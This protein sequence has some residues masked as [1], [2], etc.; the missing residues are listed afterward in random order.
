MITM[1]HENITKERISAVGYCRYS[2]DMQRDESIEAQKRAIFLFADQFGYEIKEFYVDKAKSG[3]YNNRPEFLRLHENSAKGIFKTVIIHKLDRYS[4][5]VG[6]THQYG[7]ILKSNGVSL[8]SVSEKLD[9]SPIGELMLTFMAGINRY[10]VANL[11]LEVKKGHK[12]NVYQGKTTGGNAPLGLDIVDKKYVINP[13]EAPIIRLVFQMYDEGFGYNEIIKKLKH[14]GYKSR[15]N[16]PFGKNSLYSI[17]HNEKY[18][19]HM[20]YGKSFVSNAFGKR[21]MR[22]SLE[23]ENII[24]A[25]DVIPPIIS[26]DRWERV[27]Q[28]LNFNK[29]R[30]GSYLAKNNYLL[31]GLV[32]CGECGFA[33]HGNSRRPAKDRPYY[34]SYRCNH[35]D[36]NLNC[37]CKEIKRD[38]LEEFV[39]EQLKQ[40][41]L[42]DSIIPR[43]TKEV[44]SYIQQENENKG[45]NDHQIE[46]NLKRLQ[47]EKDNMVEAIAQVG[48]NDSFAKKLKSIEEQIGV[49]EQKKNIEKRPT[50]SNITVTQ[51]MLKEFLD[52]QLDTEDKA[53]LKNVLQHYIE[54]IEVSNEQ[55]Q[56]IFKIAVASEQ[57]LVNLNIVRKIER[58]HLTA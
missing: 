39:V 3:K 1:N 2:S 48:F 33:M 51:N 57:D 44:N 24:T 46:L 25:Q 49:I 17:L 11:S 31:S 8:V 52:K 13:Q 36:N 38:L 16:R 40:Y 35:K 41:M 6:D 7:K 23:D 27:Q 50:I 26:K 22:K 9:D 18:V 10:Q 5:D 30:S 54:R 56:V 12:E 19:G 34:I 58:I 32:Y 20:V 53:N 55:V 4:R 21:K 15:T 37:K 45:T 42:N 14:L 47:K 29:R 43:L 28:R